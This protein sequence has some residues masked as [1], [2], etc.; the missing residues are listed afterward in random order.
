MDTAR[1]WVRPATTAYR[2]GAARRAVPARTNG[3]GRSGKCLRTTCGRARALAIQM[4]AGAEG[5]CE[6]SGSR[7]SARD[8]KKRY[9][10]V[11]FFFSPVFHL[12]VHGARETEIARFHDIFRTV[13]DACTGR[14]HVV[15]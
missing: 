1:V 4:V 8:R 15:W 5:A 3:G 12:A 9:P 2:D 6:I 10:L 14:N 13:P 7:P 11:A